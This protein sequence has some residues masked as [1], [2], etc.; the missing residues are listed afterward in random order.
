[1][2]FMGFNCEQEL[3]QTGFKIEAAVIETAVIETAVIETAVIELF[4]D[5]RCYSK[6]CK[7]QPRLLLCQETTKST[8][9]ITF[10][11]KQ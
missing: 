6:R 7:P 11:F 8:R 5:P 2:L 1:M 3:L 4:P 10:H 9:L